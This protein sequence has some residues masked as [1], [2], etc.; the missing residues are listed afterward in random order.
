MTTL[1]VSEQLSY[2]IL[3][4]LASDKTDLRMS[5]GLLCQMFTPAKTNLEPNGYTPS[6]EQRARVDIT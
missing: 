3:K 6:A 1:N 5:F 2:S 4:N